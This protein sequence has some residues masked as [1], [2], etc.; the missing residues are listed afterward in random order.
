M[1]HLQFATFNI[2]IEEQELGNKFVYTA[3]LCMLTIVQSRS[4]TRMNR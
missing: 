3:A 1:V 4:D 2:Q